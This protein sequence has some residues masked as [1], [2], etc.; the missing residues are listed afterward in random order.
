[1]GKKL[2]FIFV[3]FFLVFKATACPPTMVNTEVDLPRSA[4]QLLSRYF[5]GISVVRAE[6]DNQKKIY[7]VVLSKG[8]KIKFDE[9][10]Q[11]T[12]I[13]C[14]SNPVPYL[15]IPKF[16]RQEVSR[17]YGPYSYVTEIRK[18]KKKLLVTL[19][20]DIELIFKLKDL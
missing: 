14:K 1:M 10:G 13:N 11:W 17:R 12:S 4:K 19:E 3:L 7:T 8:L 2:H 16:I 5:D 6:K 18:I 20:N 9:V 15:L